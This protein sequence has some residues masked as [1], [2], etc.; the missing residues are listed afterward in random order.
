M[1]HQSGE[2]EEQ[3]KDS[4]SVSDYNNEDGEDSSRGKGRAKLNGNNLNKPKV[5]GVLA[6]QSKKIVNANA[7]NVSLKS[8][9][10]IKTGPVA[11]PDQ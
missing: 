8:K 6:G 3:N 1:E 10:N 11:D 9:V 5:G 2:S 4:Q 7:V